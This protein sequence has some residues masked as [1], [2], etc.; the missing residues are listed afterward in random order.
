MLDPSH[1]LVSSWQGLSDAR[2]LLNELDFS[3]N[4]L[5]FLSQS[6]IRDI[7]RAISGMNRAHES[8]LMAR[9]NLRDRKR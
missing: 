6:T 9:I 2:K 5:S 8:F 7:D 3:W 1:D 4:G